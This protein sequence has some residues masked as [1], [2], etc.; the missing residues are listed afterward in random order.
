M[1][2]LTCFFALSCAWVFLTDA[3]TPSEKQEFLDRHNYHRSR[4][5]RGL[6]E[7]QPPGA[8]MVLMDWEER[9]TKGAAEW[10]AKCVQRH[11]TNDDRKFG[12]YET[13]G[14]NI[15]SFIELDANIMRSVDLWF[16]EQKDYTF[17]TMACTAICGH[18]TQMMFAGSVS[19]SCASSFCPSSTYQVNVVCHNAPGGN[20]DG[21]QPYKVGPACSQCP[22][23]YPKC[24][25]GLCAMESHCN[26]AGVICN[27]SIAT[28]EA[29]VREPNQN[30][31]NIVA[32][33]ME[34][35]ILLY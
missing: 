33:V 21:E 20:Y 13:C 31:D 7:R 16:N 34:K 27:S 2:I 25:Y 8:D 19:V 14:Q 12:T 9:A 29:L 30:P 17:K 28:G 5:A 24:F 15:A 23:N 6:I 32:R 3:N 22:S 1:R 35:M 11:N 26:K 18:Y 10:A 4:V